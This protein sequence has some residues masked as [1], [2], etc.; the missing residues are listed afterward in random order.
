[1]VS[2][3]KLYAE[4]N[5][6]QCQ[7]IP[8]FADTNI[9][10]T[11]GDVGTEEIKILPTDVRVSRLSDFDTLY[12]PFMPDELTCLCFGLKGEA[13]NR[14]RRRRLTWL[15]KR[16]INAMPCILLFD[17]LSSQH[18]VGN[19]HKI[20]SYL[21]A[22]WDVR[23]SER[24]GD[25]FFN[26]DTIRGFSPRIRGPARVELK[27]FLKG[28]LVWEPRI[29]M[30]EIPTVTVHQLAPWLLHKEKVA[31][32][33]IR[34][35]REYH[36]SHICSA[37]NLG[38]NRAFK[39]RL[40]A[41]RNALAPFL[42]LLIGVPAENLREFTKIVLYDQCSAEQP[43]L[44]SDNFTQFIISATT[45]LFP[46]AVLLQGGFLG[47]RATYPEL[48]WQHPEKLPDEE[49]VGVKGDSGLENLLQECLCKLYHETPSNFLYPGEHSNLSTRQPSSCSSC[50]SSSSQQSCDSGVVLST[51]LASD[52]IPLLSRK[53][54][55][56][57]TSAPVKRPT[58]VVASL[59]VDDVIMAGSSSN[60]R[61]SR[62]R[63]NTLSLCSPSFSAS[64]S[65]AT[66]TNTILDRS[67]RCAFASSFRFLS[68]PPPSTITPTPSLQPPRP[69][70]TVSAALSA[71]A[72]ESPLPT[73]VL[74]HLLIGCQ[75][76]A[77]SAEVCADF[78]VTHII[79]VSADGEMSPHVPPSRF[80]RIPINDNGK[81]DIVPYFEK[82]FAFLDSAKRSGGRVLIHC[83]A[84]ISR[85]PTLAIAY[86]MHD[87]RLTFDEAYNRVKSIRPKISPN[88]SF[89]GQLT[90]FERRLDLP[91]PSETNKPPPIIIVPTIEPTQAATPESVFEAT[92]RIKRQASICTSV[93]VSTM[94]VPTPAASGPAR[95]VSLSLRKPS[96][97][98]L[99]VGSA[100]KKR[101]RSQYL[102]PNPASPS[103]SD[104]SPPDDET[105]GL[106]SNVSTVDASTSTTPST[107]V[108]CRKRSRFGPL[109]PSPSA[110]IASLDLSSPTE[111]QNLSRLKSSSST[112]PPP[113]S[114]RPRRL[115][116]SS[117]LHIEETRRFS[118]STFSDL[119]QFSRA[120][121]AAA[122]VAAV[123]ADT[124]SSDID[125]EIDMAAS[126]PAI[127]SSGLHSPSAHRWIIG[128][129][130][131][132]QQATAESSCHSSLS[133]SSNSQHTPS[134]PIS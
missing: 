65:A 89:I 68:T 130:C 13:F 70:S 78:G 22:E 73:A 100:S 57:V 55:S 10:L 40:L 118:L 45:E 113:P 7:L 47:F 119:Q 96:L 44:Y 29:A 111:D 67:S 81:A 14:W 27:Y 77:M 32:L 34:S 61:P 66:S 24:D 23:R 4:Y 38:G 93:T 79:N 110:A 122:A 124:A 112:P 85:S 51:E 63:P 48:C 106:A 64:T 76:D 54:V 35:F 16:G 115:R 52:S 99:V 6:D 49:F 132:H 116:R 92:P 94:T 103:S 72:F 43:L 18:R 75:S 126:N 20:R 87:Q 95:P 11:I 60:R 19:L 131:R 28:N 108:A 58:T 37:L 30:Y 83:F 107:F 134:F 69:A 5:Y 120:A 98:P 86:L 88:F 74:P 128:D 121:L 123:T 133:S 80:L 129:S 125:S 91:S 109:L 46:N 101:D 56:R 25:M 62:L 33:D 90:D 59:S 17:S 102:T 127:I 105:P 26:K 9:D 42:A 21:Q 114:P 82:A 31:V 8:D 12:A 1:M 117:P 2:Y 71:E 84:G 3:N 39:R 36:T 41:H 15:R 50:G 104:T 97:K 53:T